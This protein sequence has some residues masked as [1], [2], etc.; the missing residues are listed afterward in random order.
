MIR[1]RRYTRVS[2]MSKI[3]AEGVIR[4]RDQNRVFVE[5]ASNRK[6]SPS[7][8]VQEYPLARG[9]GNAFIE[10]DVEERLLLIRYNQSIKRDEMFIDGDVDLNNRNAQGSVNH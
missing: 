8:V 5:R 6:L 1:V 2:S 4:A 7:D 10:F 9:K 3:L